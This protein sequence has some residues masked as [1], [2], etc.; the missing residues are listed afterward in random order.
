MRFFK[1]GVP[2][3]AAMVLAGAALAGDLAHLDGFTAT[4]AFPLPVVTL[5]VTASGPAVGQPC[6]FKANGFLPVGATLLLPGQN[7]FPVP[8]TGAAF[9]TASGPGL[10]TT[11]AFVSPGN[12]G[13]N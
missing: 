11:T 8:F 12:P 7:Y 13:I 3:V 9:Y 2:A 6:F 1:F 10:E 5:V 4:T